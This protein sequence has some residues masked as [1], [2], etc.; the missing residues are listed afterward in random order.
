MFHSG[1]GTLPEYLE[2]NFK[3]LR[4]FNPD[5]RVYFLTDSEFVSD[6]LFF[7]YDII[8]LNKDNFYSDKI[9]RFVCYFKYSDKPQLNQFWVITATRL[10]YIENFMKAYHIS[11]AYHFENDILLYEDLHNLNETIVSNYP[12][13]A[14][15]VGGPDKC[16][17]GF[18]F[19]HNRKSLERMTQF[20]VDRLRIG[21]SRLVSMYHMDMVNEMTLMRAYSKDYS[22][23]LEF[24]P[25][26]PFGEFSKNYE[27]FNSIFDP[28][29]W[30]QFVGGTAQ[31]CI[32]GAKPM[33]H[34][35]G[36]LLKQ[37]PEWTVIW[38]EDKQGRKQP[39]F[40]YDNG[41]VRINNLH[42]H[43]KELSKYISL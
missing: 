11:S 15:T 21:K 27:K 25:I 8:A 35:I 29:S 38:K 37:N 30:G 42:I 16:M 26:L 12:H 6:Q 19:I 41:E 34:Y 4:L 40:K 36:P 10:M 2:D 22:D 17:T 32:P 33:D 13:M 14:I 24:L 23:Q 3:Q 31:E 1:R 18:M 9:S 20:F 28:A 7:N 43:S 5:I 39:Y